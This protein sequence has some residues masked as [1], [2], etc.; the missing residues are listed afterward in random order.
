M[1][2]CM[3][4]K[5]LTKKARYNMMVKVWYSRLLV[6][7]TNFMAIPDRY[8]DAVKELGRE[9]VKAG[10]MTEEQYELFFL[11]PYDAE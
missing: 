7:S 11:E 9:D 6:G 10:K 5:A 2:E 3:R 4:L 1:I 8:K